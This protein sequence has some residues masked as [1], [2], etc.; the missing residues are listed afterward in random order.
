MDE[1]CLGTVYILFEQWIYICPKRKG[2]DQ[3]ERNEWAGI[4][5]IWVVENPN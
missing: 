5:I 4:L 2:K 3:L 1:V